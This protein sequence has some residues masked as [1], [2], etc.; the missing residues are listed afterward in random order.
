MSMS[1]KQVLVRISLALALTAILV[2]SFRGPARGSSSL[3]LLMEPDGKGV[4]RELIA[5]FEKAHPGTDVQLIEGPAATDTREDMYSTSF[6]SG[7]AG[8]DIV[9]CDV[10]WVP[11]FAS[12]G[13]LLDLT[14]RV[15]ESDRNDFLRADFEGGM[16]KGRLYRVPAFSDA[17]VLYYRK[18]LVPR[19]PETFD[20]LE[21]LAKQFQTNNRWGFLWQGKQYEGLIAVYLETL[22]GFGGNWID[23]DTR[24]VLLDRPE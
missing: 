14:D 11:K 24:E 13:W 9:Y 18:D 12:A 21:E 20:E 19:P 10:V 5:E 15:G 23:A 4:W 22:W 7:A 6:L 2:L 16:Y 1:L 3:S 8:Y 17:G